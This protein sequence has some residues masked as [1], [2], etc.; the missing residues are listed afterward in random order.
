MVDWNKFFTPLE[1]DQPY[2]K[3]AFEGFAGSGKTHTMGALGI[4]LH[5]FIGSSKPIGYYDTEQA[6]RHLLPLFKAAGIKVF[7]KKSRTLADLDLTMR[8][9]REGVFDVLLIDSITH[10]W[11]EYL[12]AY[13]KD[14]GHSRLTME[15]WGIIKPKWK[16][17]FSEPFVNSRF[18]AIMCGRAGYE[19]EQEIDS[20]GKKQFVK[21]GI[22][23]K[24]EGDTAYEPDTLCLMERFE[25]LLEDSKKKQVWRECTVIKDRSRLLDGRT[26]VNPTFEDFRPSIEALFA[27]VVVKDAIPETPNQF[28]QEE[29]SGQDRGHE[30]LQRKIACE[31]LTALLG[32]M[33]MGGRDAESVKKRQ[34]MFDALFQTRSWTKIQQ[35]DASI[36]R[37]AIGK[38]KAQLAEPALAAEA[39][40]LDEVFS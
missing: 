5:K 3:A 23:M 26:F 16:R 1:N 2:F 12:Q 24:V 35:C 33:G 17:E 39:K 4:G 11:E 28:P 10:V 14:S 6:G 21:S 19:Y 22:K 36:I 30:L 18:H 25:E 32:T 40:E 20:R 9:G 38:L 7:H 8:A 31:E 13:Q 15:D 37:G 27:D 34:D 29:H